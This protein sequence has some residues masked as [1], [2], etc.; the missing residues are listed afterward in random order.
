MEKN[1]FKQKD[2]MKICQFLEATIRIVF[3]VFY[4]A[5][6]SLG[7]G[8]LSTIPEVPSQAT[9]VEEFNKILEEGPLSSSNETSPSFNN[10]TQK[11]VNSV[12]EEAQVEGN[13]RCAQEI[14]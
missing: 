9:S 11:S 8:R 6:N 5:L 10:K 14:V 13:I 4:D 1:H 2:K 7:G 12:G 3:M